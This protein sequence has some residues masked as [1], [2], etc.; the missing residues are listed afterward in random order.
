MPIRSFRDKTTEAVF[1]GKCPKG[2]PS[3]L[4]SVTRRKLAILDAAVFLDVL[5]SPPG[6][7]LEALHDD[8]AGQH[9]IRVNDQFRICFRWTEA[10]P[11]D[12]EFVDY[13][14]ETIM[15]DTLEIV[16]TL[17]PLHPGEVLREEFLVPLNLSAGK[18]AKACGVPRT[19]IERIA[20]EQLGV[21]GD[22]AVRLGRVLGTGPEFWM[23]LEARFEI[24]TARTALEGMLETFTEL[25]KAA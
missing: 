2:F 23:N 6:N 3:D 9:S 25:N 11:E 12:V 10:G 15:T 20:T 13:H 14:Q 4:F 24:E 1:G 21:T 8:R 17:P 7:H 19:R 22:T 16:A 18:V 5:R